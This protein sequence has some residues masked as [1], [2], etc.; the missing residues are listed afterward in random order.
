[1]SIQTKQV[2][3]YSV[4]TSAFYTEKEDRIKNG[5]YELDKLNK[6][7][8][9]GNQKLKELKA[10]KE[11]NVAEI[12][13]INAELKNVKQAKKDLLQGYGAKNKEEMKALLKSTI[14]TFNGVRNLNSNFLTERKIVAQFESSFTRAIGLNDGELTTDV[15]IVEVYYQNIMEQLILNGFT[16]GEKEYEFIFAGAGQIRDKKLVF[17]NKEVHKRILN[18][19]TAG[20]TDEKI[21]EISTNKLIAYKALVNSSSMPYA[22]F[23]IDKAI[24]VDDFEYIINDVEVDYIDANYTITRKPMNIT[25]PV[26]DGS[27]MYL[28]DD[29]LNKPFQYRMPWQKGLLIPFP[30]DEFLAKYECDGK[31]KDIYN[32]EWNVKKDDI[33]FILTKSQFKMWRYYQD[34]VEVE[35]GVFKKGWDLYKYYF[36]KYNCEFAICNTERETF[37]DAKLNYQMLQTLY[38]TTSEELTEL[39]SYSKEIINTATSSVEN[40]LEFV[41][42]KEVGKNRRSILEAAALD[43]NVISDPYFKSIVKDEKENLVN[44]IRAGS[45]I[46]KNTKRTYL[47]PDLYAFSEWLFLGE[48]NPKG[49]LQNEEVYCALY[50][51]KEL[52]IL[53]SPHLY[54]EHAIRN[55]VKSKVVADEEISKWF[56]SNGLYTSIHDPISKILMFDVD[57]D[58]ALIVDNSLF[59]EIAKRQ[60][61]ELDVVP[62]EYELKVGKALPITKQNTYNA[63]Q[64]AFSKNIGEVSNAITR[65]YNK[66]VVAKED[67]ELV[68]KLCYV[69]NQWIDYAKTLWEATMPDDLKNTYEELI[70]DKL[71]AFFKYAKNKDADKVNAVNNSVVNRIKGTFK[72]NNLMF[73]KLEVNDSYFVKLLFNKES[74]LDEFIKNRYSELVANRGLILKQQIKDE[75]SKFTQAL[76]IRKFKEDIL[77]VESDVH[78]LVDSLLLH[79]RDREGKSFIW[80]AFGDVI[81]INLKKSLGIKVESK[82]CKCGVLFESKS[83]RQKLC[84]TCGDDLKK[85]QAAER[86]RKQREKNKAS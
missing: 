45:I 74:E 82:V 11:A 64:A 77:K 63:L 62:L 20:L 69:S 66:D 59:I 4:S 56:I 29:N 41:G 46:L 61:K 58:E 85:K 10:N 37:E 65:I 22:E 53:R 14:S 26:T 36:K 73:K 57:G 51:E 12:K 78:K 33:R 17:I 43:K 18:Q 9:N 55:N 81:L 70:K 31:I 47:I 34:E 40:V 48:Q 7:I 1:M 23:D 2:S 27:G 32:K 38:N 80:E 60:I 68:K 39:L 54:V 28:A 19:I 72:T 8:R 25:N 52:D 42:V 3:M 79:T 50:D 44:D 86:K 84:T 76:A 35:E 75:K 83:N 15:F 6:N 5:I 49:L 16:F 67:I 21:G 30:Y 13:L 24:V 71:P